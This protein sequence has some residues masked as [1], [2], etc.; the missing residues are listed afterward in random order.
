MPYEGSATLGLVDARVEVSGHPGA[1]VKVFEFIDMDLADAPRS[2]YSY[3]LVIHGRQV[4]GWDCD[5]VTPDHGHRWSAANPTMDHPA[6]TV[7]RQA[8][9]LPGG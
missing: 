7:T 5:G 1:G 3:R 4:L 8:F 9:L 2:A 6:E